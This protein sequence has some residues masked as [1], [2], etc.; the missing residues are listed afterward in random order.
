[1]SWKGMLRKAGM[2]LDGGIYKF[3]NYIKWN[4][5]TPSS[6]GSN[7]NALLRA[8]TYA[9]PLSNTSEYQS[10]MI[11]FY[12]STSADGSSYDRG[13]FVCLKT[14]GK[15]SIFPIAGLA[16]VKAQSSTGPPSCMAGQFISHL[17]SAT[18]KMPNSSTTQG[19][20]GLWA[21]ITATDGATL[22][23]TTYC[24]PI[25]IDNQLYGNN[26][27]AT[28]KE[29]GIFATTGGTVP[30][31]VIGFQTTGAGWESL[32]YFDSTCY[33]VAPVSTIT[34]ATQS[35]DSDGSLIIDLNGTK[36]YIP[37]FGIAKD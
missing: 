18:A 12:M 28:T 17:N 5:Y 26:A 1:M 8:G 11:R 3:E 36:Y 25:W 15:K 37:Y 30:K 33:N 22:G 20:F 14:T 34:P 9:S 7:G 32:L 35:N 23:V 4:S 31:A 10:G 24:A 21:K 2:S 6:G 29:F 16:E 19:L 13:I 27:A